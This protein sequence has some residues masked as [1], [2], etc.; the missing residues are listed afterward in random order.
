[1]TVDSVN[2]PRH[3]TS[4]PAE[5]AA[6]NSRIECIQVTRW[7]GFN[8]G[9]A[10]KYLWRVGFGGKHNDIED[11]QKAIWYIRDEIALRKRGTARE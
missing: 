7:L 6:C 2:H 5:C 3:Y 4:S 1:M 10:I 8:I 9:N 11:L